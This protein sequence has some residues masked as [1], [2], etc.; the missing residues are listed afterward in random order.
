VYSS[1]DKQIYQRANL[2]C[3][4]TLALS[5]IGTFILRFCL[6]LENHRR[7]NLSL[8]QHDREAAIKEPCDRV[9]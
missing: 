9:C 5:L 6:I 8:E 1:A 3:V 7:D 4:G 2:I